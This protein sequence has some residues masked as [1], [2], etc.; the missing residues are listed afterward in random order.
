MTHAYGAPL[1]EWFK[2][3]RRALGEST[4]EVDAMRANPVLQLLDFFRAQASADGVKV[5]L[6]TEKEEKV[7]GTS[8]D[9]PPLG[10]GDSKPW[11]T[12][13]RASGFFNT[14]L[15]RRGIAGPVRS[16]SFSVLSAVCGAVTITLKERSLML[17]SFLFSYL[18][19]S[20][21]L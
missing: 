4:E 6:S 11:M 2:A 15:Q 12:A 7:A 17:A 8:R 20:V 21:F 19:S 14:F 16:H 13:W 1:P 9:L 3:L 5:L 18:R 10:E